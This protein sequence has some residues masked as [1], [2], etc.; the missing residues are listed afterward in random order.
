MRSVRFTAASLLATALLAIGGCIPF[1]VG[2][3][4][5]PVAPGEMTRSMSLFT[6]P[7]SFEIDSGKALSRIGVDPE[8]RF[9]FDDKSDIGLR[10]PSYSGIVVNYKRRL[11]GNSDDPG[12]AIAAMGG[13]GVVNMGDH[14]HFEFTLLASGP[15]GNVEPYGGLRVMQV[16]PISDGAVKDS[17][18]LGGFAG[19]KLN[20]HGVSL[21]PELGVFHDRSALGIRKG[22]LIIVPAITISR[23]GEGGGFHGL[24]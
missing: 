16:F 5:R 1:T 15:E 10:F 9:G 11:N 8:M 7:N 4:A 21:S 24:W 22:G 19:L 20:G 12:V 6:V 23:S 17:P 3:T 18:P 14:A 2:S 13:A